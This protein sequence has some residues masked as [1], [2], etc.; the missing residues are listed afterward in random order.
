[1]KR[2][3]PWAKGVL[4][5]LG[6]LVLIILAISFNSSFQP[7]IDDP[8]LVNEDLLLLGALVGSFSIIF[9]FLVC[10]L[11]FLVRYCFRSRKVPSE[12]VEQ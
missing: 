6:I 12:E 5:E 10:D 11:F 2:L 7:Y 8:S 9:W 1:M 4:I 3:N